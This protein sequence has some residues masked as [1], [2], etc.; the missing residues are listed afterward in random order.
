[1]FYLL[2][3][4]LV[5]DNH[6]VELG[7]QGFILL[8]W[9]TRRREGEIPLCAVPRKFD[10]TLESPLWGQLLPALHILHL[11]SQFFKSFCWC[12]K[13]PSET[14]VTRSRHRSRFK[15]KYRFQNFTSGAPLELLV[16]HQGGLAVAHQS[17]SS[18][19]PCDA[20]ICVQPTILIK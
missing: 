1:V 6:R 4:N 16:A 11:E 7:T 13:A 19:A 14:N 3:R 2:T 18:G 10:I 17:V 15:S 20:M 9:M 5:L 12:C 8:C